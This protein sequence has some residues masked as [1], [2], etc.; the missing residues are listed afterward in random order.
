MLHRFFLPA[1]AGLALALTISA[2]A[3]AAGGGGIGGGGMGGGRGMSL[4]GGGFGHAGLGGSL[5]GG[6]L[7][8][9][10]LGAGA[11]S[12]GHAGLGVGIGGEGAGRGAMSYGLGSG[13]GPIG[14]GG[15]RAPIGPSLTK[16]I[17]TPGGDDL[18]L[19]L[20]SHEL[21]L[22]SN[23]GLDAPD[24]VLSRAARV[25]NPPII[26][27]IG[28]Q[29]D[30]RPSLKALDSEM[31][32]DSQHSSQDAKGSQA[33]SDGS[34]NDSFKKDKEQAERSDALQE[35]GQML[36]QQQ[37][38]A[39]RQADL[40]PTPTPP[41]P[42]ASTAAVP[43][44]AAPTLHDVS[45]VVTTALGSGEVTMIGAYFAQHGAPVA[46]VPT[47]SV[48]VSVGGTVPDSV[49]L[50]PPPYDLV[51]QVS[52]PDFSYFVW[53]QNLVI[54]DGQTNVVSAIVPDVLARQD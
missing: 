38:A 41:S 50:F 31:T 2:P 11:G 37:L 16:G 54:V 19:G 43:S 6:G 34:K 1:V 29:A 4:G 36:L 51:S 49:A 42:A 46:A 44:P 33:S 28:T 35:Q 24:N 40:P 23:F 47:S 39:E 27:G 32:G 45:P 22:G 15:S 20:S 17:G 53:G 10:G 7:S 13:H 25:G 21:G 26:S 9:G 48:N 12:F 52:D 14:L 18:H 5:V 8:H 3:E 30:D